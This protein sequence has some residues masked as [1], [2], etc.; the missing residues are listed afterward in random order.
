M[1]NVVIKEDTVHVGVIP[2]HEMQFARETVLDLAG[3]VVV[4]VAQQERPWLL[5]ARL[6]PVVNIF[7]I[8]HRLTGMRLLLG[9]PNANVKCGGLVCS[10][11]DT[12][13]V[14]CGVARCGHCHSQVLRTVFAVELDAGVQGVLTWRSGQHTR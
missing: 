8:R 11:K 9:V 7:E 1:T 14:A 12:N 6:E 5:H 3:P 13:V 2:V 10:L 4:V